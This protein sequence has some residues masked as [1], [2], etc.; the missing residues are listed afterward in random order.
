VLQQLDDRLFVIEHP[1]RLGVAELG[2]RTTIVQLES[3][4]LFVHS[5][6]PLSVASSREIDA[7]GPVEHLVA[8]NLF[9]HLFLIENAKA[10]QAAAVHLAPGLA[11]KRKDLP[12]NEELGPEANPI[13]VADLDQ[14]ILRG[15]PAF[16]E[17]AFLHRASK[18]LILTDLAFNIEHASGLSRLFFKMMGTFGGLSTSRLLKLLTRDREEA[19]RSVERLLDWDFERIILAHGAIVETAA[20]DRLSDALAWLR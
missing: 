20:K 19:G 12:F 6:G 3:G 9:H 15:A 2:T 11:K 17:V 13:W 7:I 14:L 5:P 1:F 10:Y 18:T 16:N 8:P 4:G